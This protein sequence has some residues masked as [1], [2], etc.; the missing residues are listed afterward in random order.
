MQAQ[1]KVDSSVDPAS[2]GAYSLDEEIGFRN[3]WYKDKVLKACKGGQ[4]M[5]MTV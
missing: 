4:R 2:L 5:P 1:H 3:N